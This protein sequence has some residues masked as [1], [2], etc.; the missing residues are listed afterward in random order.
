[1]V[2]HN[3]RAVKVFFKQQT[4]ELIEKT[5][6]CLDVTIVKGIAEIGLRQ[7]STVVDYFEF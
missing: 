4:G 5:V 6:G 7:K 3:C 2:I 1:M